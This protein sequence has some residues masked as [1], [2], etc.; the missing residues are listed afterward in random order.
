MYAVIH[1]YYIGS[2]Y[3]SGPITIIL[4]TNNRNRVLCVL[5][6]ANAAERPTEEIVIN[7][8]HIVGGWVVLILIRNQ[9]QLMN[10]WT[11]YSRVPVF[12]SGGVMECHSAQ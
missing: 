2:L 11:I 3:L 12:L 10:L 8:K 7:L 6:N 4:V 5:S 1:Y 9:A